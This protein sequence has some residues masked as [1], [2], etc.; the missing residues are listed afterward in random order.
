MQFVKKTFKKYRSLVLILGLIFAMTIPMAY[1]PSSYFEVTKNLEIYISLFKEL[2]SYY[3]DDT[4]PSTL[5]KN[6]IDHMLKSLD[7]YTTY[8]SESDIENYRLQTT[9]KYG[10]IG[11]LIRTSGDYVIIAEPYKDY[12]ADK[13]KLIAGDK[14]LEIDDKSAIGK[15][16]DEISKILKGQPG[17]EVRVKLERLQQD[18]SYKEMN[19]KIER[20]EIK[21]KNVPFFGMVDEGIGYIRL[22]NFTEKAGKEVRNA[23]EELQ[24][25]ET[26]TGV[27]FDLRGNPGGLLNEAVNVSNV[28]VDKNQQIVS[29]RGKIDEWDKSFKTLNPPVDTDVPLIVL[30]DRGSASAS[31]IVS[32]SIQDLDRGLVIGQRSFGKGL[33][34]TTRTLPYNTKLKVTTAKY[35][36]PS[37][38]CIQAIDYSD[39]NDD[40]SV[41]KIPDSLRTE[42][43]TSNG[44]KVYDGGG[45]YPDVKVE[46]EKFSKIAQ[47]LITKSHIFDFAT[48]YKTKTSKI[49]EPNEFHL[50]EDE[51]NDFVQFLADKDYGYTTK[52]EE[53]V[54]D[55]EEQ[56]KKEKY[57]E[58]ISA[59]LTKLKEGLNHDKENDI[60]KNKDEIVEIL[61]REIVGR[62]YYREGMIQAGFDDDS[63]VAEAIKLLKDDQEYT[64]LLSG[65]KQ[66]ESLKD[67]D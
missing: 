46:A 1:T 28:F 62:Y 3:V 63:E 60:H 32:G 23:L 14:I 42:F 18:G 41:G 67:Q 30:T 49:A 44:R 54:E 2:N 59:D 56:S 58:A 26:L 27:I 65:A 24:E 6:S 50:S 36:I 35:Y 17:T 20:E 48:I 11:A 51:F 12:P 33:V 15:N 16:T 29:T 52:S 61:E 34:Q 10:G 40:G 53:L 13:A 64:A 31:E 57:F 5:I 21:I 19:V 39:R 47:S 55:L 66:H 7:P 37:G 22:S 25:N 43:T 4:E 9:G 38:R 8:I 45:I